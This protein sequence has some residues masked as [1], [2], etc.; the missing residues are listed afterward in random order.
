MYYSMKMIYWFIDWF[1]IFVFIFCKHWFPVCILL[2]RL[3]MSLVISVLSKKALMLSSPLS[4]PLLVKLTAATVTPSVNYIQYENHK[5]NSCRFRWLISFFSLT[6]C[7]EN[8]TNTQ[9]NRSNLKADWQTCPKPRIK[10]WN[11][12]N[13]HLFKSRRQ[14]KSTLR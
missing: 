7:L 2:F 10:M 13:S 8:N 9:F 14:T 12:I 1:K 11:H 3:K 6:Y 4:S 5:T